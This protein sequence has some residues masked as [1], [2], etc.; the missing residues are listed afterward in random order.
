MNV[1]QLIGDFDHALIHFEEEHHEKPPRLLALGNLLSHL[2]SHLH[3][4]QVSQPR[5]VLQQQRLVV[6]VPIHK[7]ALHAQTF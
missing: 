7:V 1:R 6:R 5:E 3:S 4:I 2:F